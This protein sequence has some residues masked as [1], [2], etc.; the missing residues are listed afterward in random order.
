MKSER[1]ITLLVLVITIVIMIILVG[2]GI[3][4]GWSSYTEVKLQNFSYELQQIQGRVDVIHE[5]M[6]MENNPDYVSLNGITLG[7]D[8]KD[9]LSA[10]KARET[11]YLVKSIDYDTASTTNTTLFYIPEGS[12]TYQSYYRYFSKANLESQLDIKNPK[13]DVIINFKTREL[14]SVDGIMYNEYVYYTLDE[15]K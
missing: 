7:V 10:S 6:T 4:Q 9:S 12:S 14:I 8:M 5:K 1:G 11:L 2:V 13:Q 3:N 15:M